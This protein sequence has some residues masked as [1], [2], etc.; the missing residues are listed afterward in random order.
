MKS[1]EDFLKK[2]KKWPI[3]SN[4]DIIKLYVGNINNSTINTDK[5]WSFNLT[6]LTQNQK[7]LSGNNINNINIINDKNQIQRKNE[8][9]L[10]VTDK[11]IIKNI[12]I[13]KIIFKENERYDSE[14]DIIVLRSLFYYIGNYIL[15][16]IRLKIEMKK[17]L[18][19]KKIKILIMKNL[20][21][22]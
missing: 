22:I 11:N 1:F 14:D 15:L 17:K 8:K 13:N 10:S 9:R 2:G 3:F 18:K 21:N 5:K 19:K 7:C 4:T 6:K 20:K 16:S 12:G